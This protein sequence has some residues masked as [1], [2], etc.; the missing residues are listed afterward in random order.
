MIRAVRAC[1]LLLAL[2]TTVVGCSGKP[3][4]QPAI[5]GDF[6]L[7]DQDSARFELASLRGKVV[8]V[9]FGYSQ[10]PDVCPT[11]LSKLSSVARRLG[12]QRAE[13]RVVYV[14]VDPERDTPAVL[15]ADLQ[16]F[17][18]DAVGVTGTRAEIDRVVAMYGAKYEIVQTPQSAAKYTV[19]HSTTLYLLDKQ[20]KVVEQFPYEATADEI[21]E[22]VRGRLAP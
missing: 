16:N 14:S 5:G 7:I 22:A 15:K 19:S 2:L 18:L 21:A 8:L 10:C 1:G 11:T 9:F 20:G 13:M 17:D 12:A 6:T 3:P 4:E